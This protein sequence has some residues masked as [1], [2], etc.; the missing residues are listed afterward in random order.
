MLLTD[1]LIHFLPYSIVE[2]LLLIVSYSFRISLE[3]SFS[4]IVS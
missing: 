1:I 2:V 3:S 4:I